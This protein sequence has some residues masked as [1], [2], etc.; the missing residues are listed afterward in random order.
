MLLLFQYQLHIVATLDGSSSRHALARHTSVTRDA[1]AQTATL[2][3]VERILQSHTYHARHT[4][5]VVLDLV[6]LGTLRLFVNL[7]QRPAAAL[8]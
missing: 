8:V 5:L 6:E 7:S 2:Q 3:N 1:H 4:T